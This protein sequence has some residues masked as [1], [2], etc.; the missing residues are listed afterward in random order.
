MIGMAESA[1]LRLGVLR[2]SLWYP[3]KFRKLVDR[4]WTLPVHGKH[5]LP[6]RMLKAAGRMFACVHVTLQGNMLAAQ[7][8][9]LGGL[10]LKVRL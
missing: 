10:L 4:G 2:Y 1:S 9:Q 5:R 6:N 8:R 7:K 3:T